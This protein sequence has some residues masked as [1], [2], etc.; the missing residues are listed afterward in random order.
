MAGPFDGKVAVVTGGSSGIGRAAALAFA[1]EG[2]RVAIG[3][4]RE[5]ESG[6]TVRM[7]EA[8]GGEALYSPTDVSRADQVER[9]VAAAVDR[10]GRLD[11]AFNNAGIGG[12]SFVPIPEFPEAE[13]EQVLAVNLTGVFLAMKY[14]IPAMRRTGGGAIVNM[15][16]VAGQIGGTVSA[17]YYASKHG[18]IGVTKAAAMENA[19][20]GIR[21][22]AVCPA[23]IKTD[24]PTTLFSPDLE[25][26]L[27]AM[28]PMARFGEPEEVAQ[29]V[30]WLCSDRASYIT[31]HALAI[32]GGFLA[33]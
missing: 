7:I 29:A 33:R 22:N 8:R 32:D 25:P 13:W 17:A 26:R 6:E 15:S 21:V 28:H 14:E 1:A 11:F 19:T 27:L 10:W 4:R 30:V 31:G 9:L 20:A 2:A 3:A 24:M 18:V 12:P 16:S 23:V 5:R